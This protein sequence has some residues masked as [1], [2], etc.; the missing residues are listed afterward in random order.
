MVKTAPPVGLR[1]HTQSN[2]ILHYSTN[3][4]DTFNFELKF[5]LNFKKVNWLMVHHLLLVQLL[6]YK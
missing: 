3:T 6:K 2:R 4:L 5:A 1:I